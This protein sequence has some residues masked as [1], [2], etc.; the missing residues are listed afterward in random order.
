MKIRFCSLH[1]FDNRL[2]LYKAMGLSKQKIKKY[3]NSKQRQYS[4]RKQDEL[5]VDINLLNHLMINPEFVGNNCNI[6]SETDDF[7]ILNKA[8]EIHSHP[9]SYNEKDNALSCLRQSH[10]EV[11]RVNKHHYDRGLLYRLDFDTSG[12]LIICKDDY[13]YEELRANYNKIVE[14]KEYI[15]LVEG[16]IEDQSTYDFLDTSKKVVEISDLGQEANIDIKNLKYFDEANL[17]L[18]KIRLHEGLRHQIRVLLKTINYPILGDKIYEGLVDSRLFLH[19][20]K[21]SIK[22]YG[23]YKSEEM[24]N[25]SEKLKISL[26]ELIELTNSYRFS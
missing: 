9:L 3:L 2:E 14:V 1:N 10:S 7:L 15:A 8:H 24:K 26:E 21:I 25:F 16:N 19:C 23:E 4:V 13:L 22:N 5:E 12:L 11:L 17:S 6:I 20:F 18:I